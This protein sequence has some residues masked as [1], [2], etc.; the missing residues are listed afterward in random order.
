MSDCFLYKNQP[1]VKTSGLSSTDSNTNTNFL[2]NGVD[3]KNL[4][5]TSNN[6]NI[7]SNVESGVG[8]DGNNKYNISCSGILAN[9]AGTASIVGADGRVQEIAFDSNN[10]VYIAGAF[11]KVGGVEVNNIAKWDGTSWSALGTGL[12]NHVYAMAIDSNNNVYVGGMF[13]TAGGVAAKY[14][15]KWNGSSWSALIS[16]A[17][18]YGGGINNYVHAIAIDK[19]NNVYVGGF[20]GMLYNNNI[21]KTYSIGK[22]NGSSWSTLSEERPNN[23]VYSMAIESSNNVYI[24]GSLNSYGGVAVNYI[25]KWNGSSWSALGTGLSYSVNAMAI[26]S[27]N[28]VYAGGLFTTAGGVTANNIAKWNGSSW[29]ALGGVQF[30]NYITYY[31]GITRIA[32]DKNNIVYV[33]GSFDYVHKQDRSFFLTKNIAKWDG[34]TWSVSDIMFNICLTFVSNDS[35][36]YTSANNYN[37]KQVKYLNN[38]TNI[39]KCFF[40]SINNN[41][42]YYYNNT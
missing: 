32:I 14:M 13:T 15:A 34:S 7:I 2:L 9:S 22:W 17:P 12:N 37:L 41:S 27:N 36:Y 28:N 19:N 31:P 20:G 33:G 10:N 24:G 26:D 3:V 39:S 40:N 11:T 42:L 29:S 21:L 1:L 5:L 38:Y 8:G 35:Y 4:Y 23:V 25:A 30:S 16:G 6:P 18:F